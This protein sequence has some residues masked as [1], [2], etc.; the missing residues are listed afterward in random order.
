MTFYNQDFPIVDA[1]NKVLLNTP[2]DE[3]L[4]LGC[5]EAVTIMVSYCLK[6]KASVLASLDFIKRSHDK[7]T[8]IVHTPA[9]NL[10]RR[11]IRS[12]RFKAFYGMVWLDGE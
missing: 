2:D 3:E 4:I 8:L 11:V 12:Q 10:I 9:G 1:N 6:S 7:I 5:I